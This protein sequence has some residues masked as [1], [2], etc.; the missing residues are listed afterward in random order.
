VARNKVGV[1]CALCTAALRHLVRALHRLT[2]DR[3]LDEHSDTVLDGV[4]GLG[5]GENRRDLAVPRVEDAGGGNGVQNRPLLGGEGEDRD[6]LAMGSDVAAERVG[7]ADVGGVFEARDAGAG[8][9]EG[10]NWDAPERVPP[11]GAGVLGCL[12]GVAEEGGGW[13]LDLVEAR[14]GEVKGRGTAAK[15]QADGD[16]ARE[17]LAGIANGDEEG[18]HALVLTPDDQT[19][20]NKCDLVDTESRVGGG[21]EP[22]YKSTSNDCG[23]YVRNLLGSFLMGCVEDVAPIFL[24]VGSCLDVDGV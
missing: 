18:A 21:H 23:I 20:H 7:T 16:D 24:L 22:G 14:H 9:C 15:R 5:I 13:Q 8:D 10:P 4:S 11:S 3:G 12:E 2:D 1:E 19:G 6:L 17:R